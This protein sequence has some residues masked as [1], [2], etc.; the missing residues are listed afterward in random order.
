[1]LAHKSSETLFV[2]AD[3]GVASSTAATIVPKIINAQ[4]RPGRL[5]SIFALM[6]VFNCKSKLPGRLAQPA[7]QLGRRFP[8]AEKRGKREGKWN[9]G[10]TAIDYAEKNRGC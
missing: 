10:G 5:D 3:A 9:L 7:C 4:L 1:M 6:L 8:K 2:C